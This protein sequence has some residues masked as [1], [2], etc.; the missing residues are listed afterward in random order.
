MKSMDEIF[1]HPNIMRA[2]HLPEEEVRHDP[3]MDT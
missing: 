1:R 3:H 2:Q